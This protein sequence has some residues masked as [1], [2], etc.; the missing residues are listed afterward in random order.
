LDNFDL[1]DTVTVTQSGRVFILRS[2]GKL[3][4][5]RLRHHVVTSADTAL[6]LT[7]HRLSYPARYH[8]LGPCDI[9][10]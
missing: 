2:G 1:V 10:I 9:V 4:N 8:L 5:G 7:L 3:I 6:L